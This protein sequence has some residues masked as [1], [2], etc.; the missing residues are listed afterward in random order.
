MFADG[1]GVADNANLDCDVCVVG[2]GAAGIVLALELT[3]TPLKVFVLEA[4][5]FDYEPET[6]SLYEGESVGHPYFALE[7]AR[8]RMFGGTTG[9][10]QGWCRPLDP[11]DF[12][13]RSWVPDSG[14]PITRDDLD[15]FY[16]GAN[17]YVRVGPYNYS[18]AFWRRA[19]GAPAFALPSDLVET[20]VFQYS[21]PI[22]FGLAY[23]ERVRQSPNVTVFLHSNVT[24][25]RLSS[26]GSRVERA[27]AATLT[28]K[29]FAVRASRFVVAVGGIETPRLLLASNEVA[30]AGVGNQHDLVGRYF[31]DH[32]H[33]PVAIATL[34]EALSVGSL[35]Y[36]REHVLGTAA[37]G[38]FVTSDPLMRAK[39]TLRFS[40]SLDPVERDPYV[41][42]K[43]PAEKRAEGLAEDLA[44][45]ERGLARPGKRHVF[46]LFMRAEQAPNRDSRVTLAGTRDR[47]GMR[48]ARLDWRLGELDRSS[49]A[50]SVRALARALGAAR[51]GHVYSRPDQEPDFMQRAQGGYHHMGTA[52]MHA[53]P[54]RGVVDR[55]C[56]VHGVDNLYLAGSSVF[57]TTGF[58]NPTLTIVALATRLAR[59]LEKRSG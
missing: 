11:I 2:A 4:G 9:H 27:D 42:R 57:P 5:G 3:G 34:P 33:A 50:E 18:T 30:P 16:E 37:R 58:A 35:Y 22:R 6:Q 36:R 21:P 48:E 41:D 46:S 19:T 20:S 32:P 47:L 24:S 40:A 26:T 43:A 51:L 45:V 7:S 39:R 14:W 52:R 10:W 8:L 29:R 28:G 56:R 54:R 17:R 1:R 13:E 44:V 59:H 15:P 38:V 25:V 31:A 53:D 49:I 12:E 23:R 55:D